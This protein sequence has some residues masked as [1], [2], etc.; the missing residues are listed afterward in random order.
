MIE[1]HNS[2]RISFVAQEYHSDFIKFETISEVSRREIV[3]REVTH[4]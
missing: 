1:W 3:F 2:W 4:A